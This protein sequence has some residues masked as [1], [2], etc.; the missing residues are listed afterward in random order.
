LTNWFDQAGN[1]SGQML[2]ASFLTQPKPEHDPLDPANSKA[3]CQRLTGNA[4]DIHAYL[5]GLITMGPKA[6]KPNRPQAL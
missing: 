6:H 1:F 3:W 5:I 4:N 2:L